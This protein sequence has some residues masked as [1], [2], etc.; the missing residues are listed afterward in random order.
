M[1]DLQDLKDWTIHDFYWWG[2]C[3]LRSRS[4][5][6][7]RARITCSKVQGL[8]FR[9][10][11]SGF[12]VQGSGFRVQGSR[13]RVQG[14]GFRVQG[15]GFRVQGSGFRVLGPGILARAAPGSPAP[16]LRV[17]GSGL[18]GLECGV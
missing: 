6:S 1:K 2:W 7:C 11:G 14:S 5:R 15:S 9:V 16:R 4:A 10:Q 18:G 12:R 8:G 3:L 13:F 17:W